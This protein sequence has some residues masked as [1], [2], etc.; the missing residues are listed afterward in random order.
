MF[1]PSILLF[2]EYFGCKFEGLKHFKE[3]R[4]PNFKIKS[5]LGSVCPVLNCPSLMLQYC[6]NTCLN[7]ISNFF[8]M[9]L[10]RYAAQHWCQSTY[11]AKQNFSNLH[12]CLSWKITQGSNTLYCLIDLYSWYGW[13]FWQTNSLKPRMKFGIVEVKTDLKAKTVWLRTT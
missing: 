9:G 8:C 3:L 2:F 6:S 10:I 13:G 4:A 7:K 5:S 1:S 12:S 11:S